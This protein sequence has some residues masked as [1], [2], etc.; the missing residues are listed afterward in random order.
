MMGLIV[1]ASHLMQHHASLS[2]FVII[3]WTRQSSTT[4]GGRGSYDIKV[5]LSGNSSIRDCPVA[6]YRFTAAA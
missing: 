1:C 3:E 6:Q 4:D 5:M 2:M